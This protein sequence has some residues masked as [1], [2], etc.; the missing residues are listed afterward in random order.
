MLGLVLD[1]SVQERHGHTGESL[2]KGHED[3]E[4]SGASHMRGKAERAGTVQP[5]DKKAQG[6]SY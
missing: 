6:G 4:G 2:T 5:R 1:S 3:D